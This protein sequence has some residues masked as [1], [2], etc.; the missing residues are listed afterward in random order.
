HGTVHE[1]ECLTCGRRGPMQLTLDRVR[2]GEADPLCLECGGLLKSATISFGQNLIPEV[3]GRARRA[4]ADSDVFLTIGTSL[5]VYPA[6]ALPEVAVG[7]G[8]ALVV[9]NEQPT[10]LDR[11]ARAVVHERL[12]DAL[13]AIVAAV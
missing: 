8:A 4:A 13:P 2:A 5:T 12:G 9:M 6:A 1:V 10:P 11:Y 7:S 3:L